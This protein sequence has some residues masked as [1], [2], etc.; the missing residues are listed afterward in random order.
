MALPQRCEKVAV[1]QH[2]PGER[3][4]GVAGWACGREGQQ[5]HTKKVSVRLFLLRMKGR[6]LLLMA[7]AVPL[8]LQPP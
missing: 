5:L 7:A 8:T 6:L 4:V 2:H 3:L 1:S